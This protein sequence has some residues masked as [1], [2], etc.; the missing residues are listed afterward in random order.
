MSKG[1][2]TKVGK[3]KAPMASR[4]I[5]ASRRAGGEAAEL[6]R[7]AALIVKVALAEDIG[8]GDITT[9]A[10][11]PKRMRAKAELKAKE[12]M[13]LSGLFVA[14]MAFKLCDKLAVFKSAFK[15]GD[16]VKKGAVIATVTGRLGPLL[17]AERV[18]LNF[19]QRLSG[20]ATFTNAFV[21]KVE[22]TP[23]R[24]LDT[25]KT[26]PCLRA[27][28]RYAVKSGGAQNHRSGLYDHILIKD[29]HIEAAGGVATAIGLADRLYH[30]AVPIEVEASTLS[31]VREAVRAGADIIMLDNMSLA[32]IRSAM[33][34]IDDRALLEV[35]G[36]VTL[37]SVGAIARLGVDFISVGALTHSAR[38]VDISMKVASGARKSR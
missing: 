36:G 17:T 6:K 16:T 22:R 34:I 30:G 32:R 14:E 33:K 27:L 8:G 29:N 38:S 35:S 5:S 10:V 12:G 18:A 24:I 4:R 1:K 15:D 37:G 13:V 23:A 2:V 28:E 20:I 21:K 19:L 7:Y 31:Q 3:K 26:T 9:D 11:V 25:R